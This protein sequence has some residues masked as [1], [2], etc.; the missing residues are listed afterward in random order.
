MCAHGHIF[1]FASWQSQTATKLY[2]T[3]HVSQCGCYFL[4]LTRESIIFSCVP[5]S[6]QWTFSSLKNYQNLLQK[7]VRIFWML[8]RKS[9]VTVIQHAQYQAPKTEAAKL[10]SAIIQFIIHTCVLPTVTFLLWE[11]PTSWATAELVISL[12]DSPLPSETKQLA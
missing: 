10:N 6:Y 9:T 8:Y 7:I 5:N 2:V 3:E 11:M 12:D 1:C 4:R